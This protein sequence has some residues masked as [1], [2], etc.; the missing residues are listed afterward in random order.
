M[1]ATS[2]VRASRV[3]RDDAR[4]PRGVQA[5]GVA[6]GAGAEQVGRRFGEPNRGVGGMAR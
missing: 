5:L 2:A 1:P 3:D 4:Q 6:L